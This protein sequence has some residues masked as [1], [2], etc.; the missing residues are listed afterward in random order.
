[1]KQFLSSVLLVL[2]FNSSSIAQG[3]LKAEGTKITNDAGESVL[4]RGMG[5]GGWMLQ[6]GYMM[7][8]SE[9]AGSQWKMKDFFTDLMGQQNTDDFYNL[10]LNNYMQEEDV[11]ALKDWGFNSV[12]LPLH[13][14]LFTLPIE[15]EPI[16]GENT[17]LNKGFELTDSLLSW[18][19]KH[20]V[21][22]ILD[23]HAAPGGQGYAEEISDYD[24]S[25]PSLWESMDNR[26]KTI[27]LWKRIAERYVD[28]EWIAAYDI[29]NEP[30]WD[31]P[32][33]FGLRNLYN[34]VVEAIR[35]VDQN[36][37]IIIEGNWFA[38]DFTGL[39]PPWDDNMAYG[40]H[41]Y[42]SFNNPSDNDWLT[43]LRDNNNVP[44]YLGE[45]G[46]NSNTWFTDAIRL[47]ES[48]DFGWAWWPHKKIEST[49]T[50]LS[51]VKPN[52]YQQILDYGNGVGPK[53]SADAA[54]DIMMEL[55]EAVKFSNCRTQRDVTDAM[56]RQTQTDETIPFEDHT[57]P[58]VIY[59]TDFDLGQNGHAYFDNEVAT[60]HVTTGT[61]TAWNNGWSYRNDGVDIEPCEDNISTNGYNVGWIETDEWL[62]YSVDVL[63]PGL[64]DVSFR[65]AGGADGGAFSLSAN[66]SPLTENVFVPNLGGY[67][68]W[69]T[70]VLENAVITDDV[71]SIYFDNRSNGYNC[72]SMEFGK[73]GE[74]N[75][76]NTTFT[77]GET[78]DLNTISIDLSKPINVF[79]PQ[80]F[81][82]FQLTI[83]GSSVMVTSAV[84]DPQNNRR[85]LLTPAVELHHTDLMR[86]SYTGNQILAFDNTLLESFDL[87]IIFNTLDFRHSIPGKIQA[88]DYSFQS[89]VQLEQCTDIGGGQNIGYLDTGDYLEYSV[90]INTADV[91]RLIV[92]GASDV[93]GGTLEYELEA[94]DG[95]I[96]SLTQISTSNTGGWQNWESYETNVQVPAGSYILRVN[97]IGNQ[98]NVNWFEFMDV[99]SINAVDL[100]HSFIIYPNPVNEVLN[101]KFE[102]LDELQ[103]IQLIDLYGRNLN[104]ISSIE[105]NIQISTQ[106]LNSGVYF[107][108]VNWKNSPP[109]VRSFIKN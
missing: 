14:N 34:N 98:F 12:R 8:T 87:K 60:Y 9:F 93:N 63:E 61:F 43:S 48:E 4:L 39:T 92:R 57:I 95:S 7:Q 3:F 45:S 31:L 108:K 20:E 50:P 72:S 40:P 13:Y 105:R 10:W 65:V 36:H 83:D 42:W 74:S 27:A 26:N 46:E 49:S 38:N 81:S 62:K 15:D 41:K 18:C 82:D 102:E 32:N 96:T 68:N 30:N 53:P 16:A 67:Q 97:I 23:L 91:Y 11:I 86:A 100:D 54:R 37:L 94:A 2:L 47:L 85:I 56:F 64:Y 29:L 28:E 6:E 71:N 101:L 106:D 99:S 52:G 1:M 24:P 5:L 70:V 51:I 109:S 22:I 44:I 25:K 35:E 55:A 33:G 103:N 89:G 78:V 84:L 17:W 19:E 58:G 21:Y 59:A 79:D 77:Y 66:G 73:V 88:E 75:E 104:Q 80:L 76:V 107:I 69:S 90:D